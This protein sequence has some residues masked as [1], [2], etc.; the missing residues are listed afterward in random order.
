LDLFKSGYGDIQIDDA[1]RETFTPSPAPSTYT[2]AR[3]VNLTGLP[4]QMHVVAVNGTA[5]TTGDL[6]NLATAGKF[7]GSADL[8]LEFSCDPGQNTKGAGCSTGGVTGLLIQTSLGKK[9]EAASGA[10]ALRFG[11][12]QCVEADD[13]TPAVTH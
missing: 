4:K 7:D 6:E 13:L 5:A 8:T 9:W 1:V 11:T 12:A 3:T 2:D 10:N